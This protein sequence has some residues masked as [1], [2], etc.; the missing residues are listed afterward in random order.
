MPASVRCLAKNDTRLSHRQTSLVQ[1]LVG[2]GRTVDSKL[3]TP[4]SATMDTSFA[5]T[6]NLDASL[7]R[8][9]GRLG[10]VH[11]IVRF[12][13]LDHSGDDQ[14]THRGEESRQHKIG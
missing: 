3:Q 4:P 10:Y 2:Y 12:R 9:L 7:T 1:S 13:I 11:C 5:A 14:L 8:G 6:I